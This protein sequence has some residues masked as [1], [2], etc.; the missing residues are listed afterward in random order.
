MN[1]E[2]TVVVGLDGAGFDLLDSWLE[3][4]KLPTIA[5]VMDSGVRGQLESVLPPVTSPN[6]KAYATGKN[7]GK[8]GIYWWENIDVANRRVYYPSER[9]QTNTE[10][11]E[12]LANESDVGVIGVPTTY[13]PKRVGSFFVSGAPDAE[14][15]GYT[16]PPELE[17]ELESELGYRVLKQNRIKDDTNAAAEEILDLIDLR[18]KAAKYLDRQYNVD[19]LQIA[20]FYL[21]SLHHYLW[22]DDYTL[23]AWQLIDNHLADF[24]DDETNIILM[25][26]H[27]SN[28][29]GTVFYINTWLAENGYLEL[30]RDSPGFLYKFGIQKDRLARVFN[31]LGVKQAAKRMA[32]QSLLNRIP[33]EEGIFKREQKTNKIDWEQSTAVASGQGPIYLTMDPDDPEREIVREEL[34]TKLGELTDP[35]LRQIATEIVDGRDAYNGEY[36]DE[37][38]DIV[39]DQAAGVHIPGGIGK[40][41]VFTIPTEEGWKAENRRYGLFAASGPDMGTGTV[42]GLSILDLAPTLLHLHGCPVPSSMDG[43]VVTDIFDPQSKAVSKAINRQAE[44]LQAQELKRV[45]QIARRLDL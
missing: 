12:I 6:W 23:E 10:Y 41:E 36:I 31:R 42:D 20:T 45:R 40:E 18:F 11:W 5:R 16:H 44:T 1:A 19:F 4:G 15:T 26:D 22:D 28:P 33:D 3:E 27:G 21:N 37:S 24:V 2:R 35:E 8:I 30:T 14:E 7:P 38:P 39:I 43:Q 29:I 32:P 25:S 34:K 9:K 17:S 13:P